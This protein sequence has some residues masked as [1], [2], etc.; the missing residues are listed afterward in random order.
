MGTYEFAKTE[1]STVSTDATHHADTMAPPYLLVPHTMLIQWPLRIYWCHTLCW[2][3]GPSVSTDATHH[4][5]TMAPPYLLVPH[6]MLIQ[7]PLRIYWCHKTAFTMPLSVPANVLW[8]HPAALS[9][10]RET[11]NTPCMALLMKPP[12]YLGLQAASQVSLMPHW[13]LVSEP[14]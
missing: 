13:C 5:D 11:P 12:I 14:A 4:A 3:N 7:W 6:T 10:K 1:Y 2:Y 8:V 9:P